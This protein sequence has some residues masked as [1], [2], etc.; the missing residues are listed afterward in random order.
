MRNRFEGAGL[1]E[2]YMYD[3]V[4]SLLLRLKMSCEHG[5]GGSTSA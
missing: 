5:R 1:I 2:K 4:Y 3:Q